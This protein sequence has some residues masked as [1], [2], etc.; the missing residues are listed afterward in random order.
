MPESIKNIPIYGILLDKHCIFLKNDIKYNK[1]IL[2]DK[3]QNLYNI[4]INNNKKYI[5]VIFPE[6]YIR[7]VDTI[8][9]N[10]KWSKDNDIKPFRNLI[11]PYINEISSIT[12]NFKQEKT[13]LTTLI[14][15][16]DLINTKS[17]K[18]YN[19]IIPNIACECHLYICNISEYFT[20]TILLSSPILENSIMYNIWKKQ[21]KLID[22][23][24]KYDIYKNY[25]I[26]Y[27]IENINLN[28]FYM[29]YI[30]MFLLGC[31]ILYII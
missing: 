8:Y 15:S 2:Y 10:N 23:I 20:S 28:Q 31:F 9:Q 17:K 16:D 11:N 7:T 26:N 18:L 19:F 30:Y 6:R 12:E 29:L 3:C 1:K 24:Y 27:N 21:D 13:L 25:S 22:S 14:Y 5:V 4:S